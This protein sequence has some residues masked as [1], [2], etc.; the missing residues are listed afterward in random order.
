MSNETIDYFKTKYP[1][2]NNI[3]VTEG[4]IECFKAKLK[5]CHLDDLVGRQRT[6]KQI[7]LLEDLLVVYR[8]ETPRRD[9]Q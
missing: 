9:Q 6:E 5:K 4:D 2:S 7:K 8:L 1:Q 3:E